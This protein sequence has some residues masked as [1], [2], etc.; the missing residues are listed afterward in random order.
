MN[1]H[2]EDFPLPVGLVSVILHKGPLADG[3][4]IEEFHIK[5]LIVA[6]ASRF[7][8]KRMRPGANWGAGITHLEVGTGVG[9][10]TQ[11]SPQAASLS[12][13][14]LRSPLA[15]K[16]ITSWTYLDS[17]GQ[18]TSAE[19]NI[20]QLTTT[21]LENEANGAVVEMGMFG[22][23]ASNTLGSGYMF[24]YKTVPVINKTSEYQLTFAWRLTF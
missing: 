15:R 24:N 16:A 10:G 13:T 11:A 12:Q 20:L 23:D 18:A 5:N 6:N 19:S 22:G 17:N 1:M 3:Q 7:M 8:A 14:V 4:I 2:N 9:D 21:F